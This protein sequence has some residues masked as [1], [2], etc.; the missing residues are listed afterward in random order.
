MT[1]EQSMFDE[2]NIWRGRRIT[3]LDFLKEAIVEEW[4]KIPHQA[5]DKCLDAFKPRLRNIIEV[6][7]RHIERYG[8]R[9]I[10]R[11]GSL[12]IHTDTS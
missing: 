1:N 4:N 2:K 9:H 6:G 5:I 10:E 8:G 3:D 12:I 7:G 11:Y